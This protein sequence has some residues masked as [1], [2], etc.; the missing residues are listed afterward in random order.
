MYTYMCYKLFE[1]V[2]PKLIE[3]EKAPFLMRTLEKTF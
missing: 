3:R 2:I 1:I